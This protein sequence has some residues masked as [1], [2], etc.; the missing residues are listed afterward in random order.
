LEEV[1]ANRVKRV[2]VLNAS[3]EPLNVCTVRR[4][5]ELVVRGK[6]EV[7]LPVDGLVW[8][9]EKLKVPVPSVIRLRYYVRV[10]WL[11][12]PLNKKNVLRRDN[13]T[14]QYC[15][16]RGKVMTVDHVVPKSRGGKDTWENLVC[17]CPRCNARKG[18]RTPEEAG[19]R[20][21]RPPRRPTRLQLLLWEGLPDPRWRQF[22]FF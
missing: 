12:V 17:A 15:G 9:A 11:E 21:L 8:R 10:P 1:Q 19:M 13:Y 20:L 16:R 14:C 4:G 18:E 3:Y 5:V 2:L 22:L 7:I 6:A